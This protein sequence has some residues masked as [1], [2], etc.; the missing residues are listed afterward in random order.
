V[1]DLLNGCYR[2]TELSRSFLNCLSVSFAPDRNLLFKSDTRL[3]AGPSKHRG[4][5][6]PPAISEDAISPQYLFQ[7][8]LIFSIRPG[9]GDR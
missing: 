5:A 3:N 6:G 1:L 2:Y 9:I 7:V 4:Q 8:G